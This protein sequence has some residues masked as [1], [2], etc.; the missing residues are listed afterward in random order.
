M[1]W[2]N[3]KLVFLRELRDQLR[4][5]RTLFTV[6]VLPILLYP[7]I[8]MTFLQVSQFMREHPTRI[9]IVGY[10][11]AQLDVDPPLLVDG[12]INGDL[13][14]P[15]DAELL[16]LR[17]DPDIPEEL[18]PYVDRMARG[19]PDEATDEAEHQKLLAILAEQRIDLL[20][21]FPAQQAD[22]SARPSDTSP[23]AGDASIL[24]STS[25][26][27]ADE[28][29]IETN[30]PPPLDLE[31]KT[32]RVVMAGNLARDSSR[33][34][35]Q[36][37]A[38]VL[39]QWRSLIIGRTLARNRVP[40]EA[41]RPFVVEERDLSQ[42]STRQAML[43]SKIL[44]FVMLLWALTGAFYP[45]IDSCAG[46]KER[47]TLETMLC[48]PAARSEIVAGKLL[49][50]IAFSGLTS[51][52]NLLSMMLSGYL[53]IRA[54][55]SDGLLAVG[56]PPLLALFWLVLALVPA[57]ALFGSLALAIAV[58]ARS[59]KEGQYYLM[60]LLL[61]SLP[62]LMIALLP[63]TELELGTA[64]IPLTGL[65][66]LL[67]ELIEGDYAAAL[68]FAGPVLLVTFAAVYFATRW[69]VAQFNNESVIFR[70]SEQVDLG[71]WLR[72]L[73]RDRHDLPSV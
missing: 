68:T 64:V 7:F 2:T 28:P 12:Q 66:L 67:R 41:T 60:P 50:I 59:T 11:S 9:W 39:D 5:R 21:A 71:L 16:E 25:N 34:A 33:V 56:P 43:W 22:E 26:E 42:V 73:V 23:D 69:A 72:H 18:Q 14:D 65:M 57:A 44:P 15:A 37:V 54:M 52:L 31:I 3:I 53:L 29:D 58:F 46:E 45:A 20:I 70:E 17:I 61:V 10:D 40:E 47:G 8:G 1:S 13:I 48:G 30:L 51:L 35:R 55:P 62:L 63:A 4:D 32:P 6:L 38:G 36:R 24:D 49:T 19:E 27:S